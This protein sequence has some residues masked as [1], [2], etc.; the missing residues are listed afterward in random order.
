MKKKL[1]KKIF[2]KEIDIYE[3]KI[4][5]Y[6][7]EIDWLKDIIRIAYDDE[8]EHAKMLQLYEEELTRLEKQNE[9][10]TLIVGSLKLYERGNI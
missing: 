4:N 5:A 1:F 6:E 7:R 9:I 2:K 10:L 3:E 8:V